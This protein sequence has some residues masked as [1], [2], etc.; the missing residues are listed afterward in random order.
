MGEP[1]FL[2]LKVAD[3]LWPTVTIP[4]TESVREAAILLARAGT[5]IAPVVSSDGTYEGIFT[6]A[7]VHRR[8]SE[9]IR[10]FHSPGEFRTGVP[11]MGGPLPDA[12]WRQF[13]NV[14]WLSV[15]SLVRRAQAVSPE[16]PVVA[17]LEVMRREAVSAIPIVMGGKIAGILHADALWRRRDQVPPFAPRAPEQVR[18][19]GHSKGQSMDGWS[20]TPSE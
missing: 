3:L 17:A 16:D 11:L 9:A 10:G 7:D 6:E 8:L 4:A 2:A 12:V 18:R 19:K 14:G 1:R 5:P 20:N 13:G 15:G